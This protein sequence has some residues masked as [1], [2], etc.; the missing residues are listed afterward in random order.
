MEPHG[1]ICLWKSLHQMEP[2]GEIFLWKI[3]HQANNNPPHLH[4]CPGWWEV[5]CQARIKCMASRNIPRSRWFP[6]NSK[7]P[8]LYGW[9]KKFHENVKC[10]MHFHGVACLIENKYMGKNLPLSLL[11]N[12]VHFHGSVCILDLV[13]CIV[14]QRFHKAI[15][16]IHERW[17]RQ[18]L[19]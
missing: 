16:L 4:P 18:V 11:S 9:D 5:L 6:L 8:F 7:N 13:S 2:H 3:L 14:I 15:F 12:L 10:T 17:G 19:G 1:E